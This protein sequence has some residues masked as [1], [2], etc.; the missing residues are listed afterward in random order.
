[1]N[2]LPTGLRKKYGDVISYDLNM[3]S[4]MVVLNS[5][6]AIYEG[7]VKNA[8]VLSSRPK[9]IFPLMS[10]GVTGKWN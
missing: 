6:D 10:A 3:N 5:A 8:D 1:M 9:R 4:K 2:L 7:F